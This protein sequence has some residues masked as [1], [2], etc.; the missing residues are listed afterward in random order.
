M[1]DKDI[2]IHVR[3]EGTKLT[4]EQLDEISRALEQLGFK[5]SETSSQGGEK[6]GFFASQVGKLQ[7]YLLGLFGGVA[8]IRA[9]TSAINE[10]S[11]AM[12][13]HAKIALE[14]QNKL[15]RLQFLGDYYKEKP[16]L[17][18][19]VMAYAEAGRRPF[20]DVTAAMYDLRNLGAG[21]SAKQ[22]QDILR[23][24][25]ELGRT[26][27]ET[28][29]SKIVQSMVFYIKQTKNKDIGQVQNIIKQTLTEAGG[30]LGEAAA[31]LSKFLPLG[32]SAGLTGPEAAGVWAFATSQF[33]E[34]GRATTGLSGIILALQGKGEPESQRLLRRLGI[35]RDASFL[36][37]LRQLSQK[38]LNLKQIET[39]ASAREAPVLAAL[40]QNPEL[41]T[42]T[43]GA[44]T[45]AGESK[46]DLTAKS[47]E[48]LYGADELAGL[49]DLSRLLDIQIQNIKAMDIN[50]VRVAI[51]MKLQEKAL[52]EGG[53]ADFMIQFV[54]AT[55]RMS[56]GLRGKLI[57]GWEPNLPFET[58]LSPQQEEE[59]QRWKT[60]YAPNDSGE[61]Y[62]LRG[63][64]KAGLK[65]D[66]NGHWPDTFKK[67]NHP[68][69]SNESIYSKIVPEKAGHW[70]KNKY[71][72]PS[73]IEPNEPNSVT[74]NNNYDRSI[75]Y[76]PT[77]G[78]WEPGRMTFE[79]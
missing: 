14:Q 49:E 33:P 54:R 37:Q 2:N 64:F 65:P 24:S 62:D 1:S 21:L 31:D 53:V 39:I 69:F 43:I 59:F 42:K 57:G 27:P 6:L 3:A 13:E 19:E 32:L 8:A 72:P 45:A 35:S 15:L 28:P 26:M 63:A 38:N 20:E 36:Q 78:Y 12:E 71:I 41:L 61:D 7:N 29:L 56:A 68:T 74:I 60:I 9:V 52:R 47:I 17:R 70:E 67:P 77:V 4:K 25:L 22:Q 50:A 73:K 10:Q 79:E 55:Q 46:E 75:N 58:V 30:E 5:V 48:E 18:K 66:T 44:V 23:E 34:A 11:R 40:L 76:Y 51:G 16:E